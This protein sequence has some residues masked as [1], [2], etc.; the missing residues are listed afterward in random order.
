[1]LL[2]QHIWCYC[3][4]IHTYTLVKCARKWFKTISS[5]KRNAIY[6][7]VLGLIFFLKF[8]FCI[9]HQMVFSFANF[10]F[11]IH[12]YSNVV[13]CKICSDDKITQTF[14]LDHL[15]HVKFH[16]LLTWNGFSVPF[17]WV[18]VENFDANMQLKFKYFKRNFHIFRYFNQPNAKKHLKNS[19][20]T[21]NLFYVYFW[22]IL[23]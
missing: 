17:V 11:D 4:H 18:K 22:F 9:L 16:F 14:E 23:W 3:C 2:V 6:S 20:K 15:F 21:A 12:F 19:Q 1:M 7:N 5:S 10:L 8:F 13:K